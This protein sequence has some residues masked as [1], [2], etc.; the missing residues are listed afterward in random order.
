MNIKTLTS[1]HYARVQAGTAQNLYDVLEQI[2]YTSTGIKTRYF[3]ATSTTTWITLIDAQGE[4]NS[5]T[6]DDVSVELTPSDQ[7]VYLD[8]HIMIISQK[9]LQDIFFLC[10][11]FLIY[12]QFFFYHDQEKLG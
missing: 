3:T 4:G 10:V 6:W 8:P 11:S 5:S 7:Y 1:G 12:K 2:T 9:L